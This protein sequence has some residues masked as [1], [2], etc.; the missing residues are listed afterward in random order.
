MTRR[1]NP[2]NRR[3][4]LLGPTRSG[5]RTVREVTSRRRADLSRIVA[6]MPNQERG[7]L[8]VALISIAN[9]AGEI[10]VASPSET[11]LGW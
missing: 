5:T 10:D 4:M 6:A 8:I 7:E 3:Q 9:A 1:E 11:E 2:D